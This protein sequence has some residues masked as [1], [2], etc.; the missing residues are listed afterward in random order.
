MNV[1]FD[2]CVRDYIPVL[3]Q[4][5]P[6]VFVCVPLLLPRSWVCP[7]ATCKCA[8][9]SLYVR[10]P[11]PIS[12]RWEVAAKR[13]WQWIGPSSWLEIFITAHA[14]PRVYAGKWSLKDVTL[15]RPSR[16]KQYAI[17]WYI[18]TKGHRAKHYV[19]EYR[20]QWKR[21]SIELYNFAL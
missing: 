5:Q 4:P 13:S 11:G 8:A 9:S 1:H 14:V 3:S 17:V 12:K 21:R 2:Q 18:R 20:S 16:G 10:V 6:H 15:K 19:V 7:R